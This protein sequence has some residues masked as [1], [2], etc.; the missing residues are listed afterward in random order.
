MASTGDFLTTFLCACAIL[1]ASAFRH[2]H[3]SRHW[4]ASTGSPAHSRALLN[5]KPVTTFDVIVHGAPMT[6]FNDE[7]RRLFRQALAE[8][9]GVSV[10]AVII[11]GVEP[12]PPPPTPV[13]PC[14]T[15]RYRCGSGHIVHRDAYLRAVGE[16]CKEDGGLSVFKCGR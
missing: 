2:E 7:E 4:T 3:Q 15:V 13:V 6:G 5:A 9:V 14:G 1:L 8:A 16:G 10:D 11:T 12:A